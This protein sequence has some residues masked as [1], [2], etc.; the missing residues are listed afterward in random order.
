MILVKGSIFVLR[1]LFFHWY[2]PPWSVE[3]N[4]HEFVLGELFI[5]VCVGQDH[6]SIVHFC[7][8]GIFDE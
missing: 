1:I 4:E 7:A 2:L 5:E 8:K 6:N 3:F